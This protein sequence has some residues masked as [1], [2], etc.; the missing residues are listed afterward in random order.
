[1][2]CPNI[3][4]MNDS[5]YSKSKPLCSTNIWTNNINNEIHDPCL[6]IPITNTINIEHYDLEA[7]FIIQSCNGSNQKSQILKDENFTKLSYSMM[8]EEFEY[9]GL[10]F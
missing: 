5:I 3:E 2:R 4:K 9:L 7:N 8:M 1:M 10:L 6:T